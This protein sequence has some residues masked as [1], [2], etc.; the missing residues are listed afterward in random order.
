MHIVIMGCGR[1]GSTLAHILEDKGHSVAIID[2]SPEAFRRLR[3]GF[4]GRRV[5]G[6]GFDRDVL[7]EAGIEH[8]SAFVAVSSGDNSNII[9]ARVARETFGVENVVARIYDPRRAEVYQRLGIPTVATV[10]WTAD[11]ILR[12]LLPDGAMPL[13]RD[14]NGEVILAELGIDPSWVG[15]KV[16]TFEEAVRTRVAFLSR[17]GESIVPDAE[18]V[19]QDGDIVHVMAR[20]DDLERLSKAAARRPEGDFR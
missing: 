1:V 15:T 7:Q 4:R 17:M 12:R 3:G 11:Q 8:A 19:I 14:P 10:R 9:S 18:T 5:T 13:W 2:Q 20:S 6:V 16:T